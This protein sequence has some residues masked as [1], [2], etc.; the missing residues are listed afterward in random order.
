VTPFL[1][2]SQLNRGPKDGSEPNMADFRDSGALE[3]DADVV[4]LLHRPE[5][6]NPNDPTLKGLAKVI[7]GKQRNGPVG[8][9]ELVWRPRADAV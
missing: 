3:Q 6:Y 1:V 8:T 2:L 7:I 9:V 5:V 4:L